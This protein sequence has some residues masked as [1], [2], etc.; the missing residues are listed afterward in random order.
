MK[1]DDIRGE[2]IEYLLSK[3]LTPEQQ[4]FELDMIQNINRKHAEM[5]QA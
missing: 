4:R 2:P 1:V 5:R 3:R